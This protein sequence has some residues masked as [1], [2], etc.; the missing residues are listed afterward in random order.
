MNLLIVIASPPK[1]DE[2][3]STLPVHNW[4]IASSSFLK[5]GLLAMT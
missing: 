5:E 3:I 2:A 4:G 1:A